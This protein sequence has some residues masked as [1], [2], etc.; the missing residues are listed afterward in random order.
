[1]RGRPYQ[2]I[3]EVRRCSGARVNSEYGEMYK[4]GQP[5]VTTGSRPISHRC[6]CSYCIHSHFTSIVCCF[7][8]PLLCRCSCLTPT[9]Y[10]RFYSF[11]SSIRLCVLCTATTVLRFSHQLVLGTF[12]FLSI[13]DSIISLHFEPVLSCC[14]VHSLN[15]LCL[16]PLTF[17]F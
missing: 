7:D 14:A 13:L 1:M 5:K 6:R 9:V 2:G 3:V 10:S 11:A 4:G 12:L 17:C 16:E 8:H 15:N